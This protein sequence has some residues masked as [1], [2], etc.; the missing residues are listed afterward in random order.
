MLIDLMRENYKK[1]DLVVDLQNSIEGSINNIVFSKNDL[2]NQF[3]VRDATW[4]LIAWEKA[5]DITTDLS[6]S[7]EFRRERIQSKLRGTGTTTKTMLM[8][9]T[10]AF[11]G[12]S[13]V[14]V[15]DNAN[16]HFIIKFDDYYRVPDT[17]SITE[18]H[19]ITDEIKPSHLSYDHT[20]TYDYWNN[21][22]GTITWDEATTW[23]SLRTYEEV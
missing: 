13:C 21:L 14:L 1:S 18:I 9:M 22:N 15:E 7:Y 16:Y 4:G 12:G 23:D 8:N 11:I 3:F 20:F 10:K 19:A 2:F 17:S 6:K 5:L